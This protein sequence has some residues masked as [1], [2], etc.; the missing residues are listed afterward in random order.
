[1]SRRARA[2][3]S[4]IGWPFFCY[5]LPDAAMRLVDFQIDAEDGFADQSAVNRRCL[6]IGDAVRRELARRRPALQ[7]PFGKLVIDLFDTG[8]TTRR[9]PTT[10]ALSVARVRVGVT[11]QLLNAEYT[12]FRK[13]LL[14]AIA[15][16]LG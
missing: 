12:H 10:L 14:G 1:M 8:N 4:V 2:F 5:L 15:A 16:S 9:R 13:G 3:V 6:H 7:A 11:E